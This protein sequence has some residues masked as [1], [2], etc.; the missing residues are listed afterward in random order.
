MLFWCRHSLCLGILTI[1]PEL[2]FA[3]EVTL[4]MAANAAARAAQTET[5]LI[6]PENMGIAVSVAISRITWKSLLL[7]LR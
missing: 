7:Q 1:Q 5:K 6:G 3:A 2:Y 4:D